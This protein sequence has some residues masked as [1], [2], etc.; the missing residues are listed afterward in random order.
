MDASSRPTTAGGG[1]DRPRKLGRLHVFLGVSPGVGKTA[2]MMQAALAQRDA[3]RSVMI[4]GSEAEGLECG[5]DETA[6]QAGGAGAAPDDP[7]PREYEIAALLA[8]EPDIVVLDALAGHADRGNRP[9]YRD[10]LTLLEAGIDVYCTLNVYEI[11]SRADLLWRRVGVE[12]R[13]AVPDGA[14]ENAQIAFVDMEPADL[15]RRIERGQFRPPRKLTQGD[16]PFFE[17]GH[18]L[19]LREM[20]ARLLAERAARDAQQSRQTKGPARSGHRL[21]LAI[22]FGWDARPLILLTRRLAGSLNASWIVFCVETDGGRRAGN[23]ENAA[24]AL[25][26][27][28]ELGAEVITTAADDFVEAVLRVARAR[29]ITQ[30]VTGKA[31]E[32]WWHRP[33]S[34]ESEF[35]ALARRS[36][37]I[38]VHIAAM[39]QPATEDAAAG[40]RIEGGQRWQWPAAIGATIAV[41]LGGFAIR[42]IIQPTAASLLSLLTIVAVAAFLQRGPAL[43]ATTLIATGWDYFFLPPYFAFS[44]ARPEDKVL[45]AMYFTVALILGQY[46]SRLRAAEAA[47]RQREARATALYL[48]TRELAE[49]GTE[50]EI[51]EKIVAELKR[52]FGAT[53]AVLLPDGSNRLQVQPASA[54][55]LGDNEL[56]AAAWVLERRQWAGKFTGNLSLLETIFLPLESSRRIVGVVGLRLSRSEPPTIHERNL[57]EALTR[58]AAVAMERL[59]LRELSEKTEI[60]AASERLGKTLL[61]SMSHEMRTP[62]AAIHTAASDLEEA[63]NVSPDG[64]AALAEIQEAAARLNRLVGNVLDITRLESGHVKPLFNECDVAEIA[65]V[66]VKETCKQMEQHPL[67]VDL[68]PGLPLIRTDFVFVQQALMNLLANAAT[69]TAPGTAVEL[70]AWSEEGWVCLAVADRGPGIDV[71]RLERVFDKFYRGPKAPTGGIG[72]GLSLVKGFVKAVGGEVTAANRDGGGVAFTIRLPTEKARRTRAVAI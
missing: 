12:S 3:G 47:E 25:E 52:S 15:L 68:A 4:F 38:D 6:R 69:H 10:A 65:H 59:R 9:R 26:L 64:R 23:A 1:A 61:D 56:A 42:P 51:A 41:M 29:N 36:D 45:F 34:R 21:L 17:L 19:E 58:Q 20:A 2:A 72:L 37:G 24:R 22:K 40:L 44:I 43:L 70:R 28:R 39:T 53:A 14:L 5:D 55:K 49:A 8:R 11:A 35:A 71:E 27:A 57:L 32:A 31:K 13:D 62:L 18:L 48:L 33:F 16:T 60:I 66:A 46:T 50:A 30:I 54:L 67:K 63:G 7:I